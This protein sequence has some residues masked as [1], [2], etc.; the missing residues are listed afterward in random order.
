MP[1]DDVTGHPLCF[2]VTMN[3]LSKHEHE[4]GNDGLPFAEN[5]PSIAMSV[6]PRLLI[7][8]VFFAVNRDRDALFRTA[9]VA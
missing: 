7:P 6:R 9:S 5:S 8:I 3:R 1:A 4:M 2:E